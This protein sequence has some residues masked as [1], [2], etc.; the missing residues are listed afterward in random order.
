[1]IEIINFHGKPDSSPFAANVLSDYFIEAI[2]SDNKRIGIV[3][4]YI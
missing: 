1:M 2:F 3:T 4:E